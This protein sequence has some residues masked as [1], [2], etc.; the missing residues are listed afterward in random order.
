MTVISIFLAFVAG[1]MVSN[2]VDKAHPERSRSDNF[3]HAMLIVLLFF[4]AYTMNSW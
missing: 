1:G 2:L 3:L 4:V